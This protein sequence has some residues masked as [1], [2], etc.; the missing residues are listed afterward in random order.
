LSSLRFFKVAI[1]DAA[2]GSKWQNLQWSDHEED[3]T[4]VEQI[5]RSVVIKTANMGSAA[6]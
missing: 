4:L 6:C 1:P 3:V 2:E 5:N